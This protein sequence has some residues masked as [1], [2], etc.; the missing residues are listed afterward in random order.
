NGEVQGRKPN[1]FIYGTTADKPY[2]IR[3]KNNEIVRWYF[4]GGNLKGILKKLPYLE[5]LG[6]TTI[7]LN[8]IF[9][10]R[11]NHHYDTADFLKIDPMIGNEDDLK[12]LITEMH[13]KNMNLILDGVFNHVGKESIY[14]NASGSYGKTVGAA[15]SKESPYYSWFDF[16][17]YPDNYKSW[18]GIKDLQVIDK[19]NSEYQKFIYGDSNRSVLSKWNNFGIDGWRL[20]V[21]DELP[22]N[23]L[24]GIRKN[25]DSHHKQVMIGEV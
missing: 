4:Y 6:V 14:S 16:L 18:W 22:M 13:K 8:P 11:S 15:Q 19:D 7:Y 23:F 25:L 17:Y 12:E 24:R 3:D 21:A 5:K 20:D 2:Y 10:S 9:L 1:S